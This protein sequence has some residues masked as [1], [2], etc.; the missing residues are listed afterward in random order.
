MSSSHFF[1]TYDMPSLVAPAP[2]CAGARVRHGSRA[3]Q[4]K[5]VVRVCASAGTKG[6]DKVGSDSRE[7]QSRPRNNRRDVVFGFLTG[8]VGLGLSVT[9]APHANAV[10]PPATPDASTSPYIQNLL[11]QT[12][13]NK[14]LRQAELANKNCL[15]QSQMGIGDCAGLPEDDLKKAM[16]VSKQK[17][18]QRLIKDREEE[19]K[20]AEQVAAYEASL[21]KAEEPPAVLIEE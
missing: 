9:V 3:R 17:M 8:V 21:L 16:E 12:E 10:T 2:L 20:L 4:L 19:K 13:E 5:P 18:E 15:R 14:D 11:K 6:T 7:F 1:V